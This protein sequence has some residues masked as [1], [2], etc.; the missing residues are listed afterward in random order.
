MAKHRFTDLFPTLDVED[1][2]SSSSS[3]AA[4]AAPLVGNVDSVHY[5]YHS[6][7][8]FIFAGET[9]YELVAAAAVAAGGDDAAPAGA[10]AAGRWWSGIVEVGPWYDIWYDICDVE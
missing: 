6:R 3:A 4:A 9:V 10:A 8:V 2:S 7:A 5:S 1:R